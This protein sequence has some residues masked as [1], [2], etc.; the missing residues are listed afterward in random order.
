VTVILP[1]CASC[2]HLHL[3]ANERIT[4]NAFPK[5][6]PLLI[7]YADDHMQP[8]PGDHGIQ[9]EPL[10][11]ASEEPSRD[12]TYVSFDATMLATKHMGE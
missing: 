2:K 6:I 8:H 7:L 1:P 5:G 10:F 3:R 9:Y 4:C 11:R 12:W